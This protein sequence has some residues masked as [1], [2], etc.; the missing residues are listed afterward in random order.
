M[1]LL[2]VNIVNAQYCKTCYE[3][4]EV[5][6]W[7]TWKSYS[8]N[9]NFYSKNGNNIKTSYKFNIALYLCQHNKVSLLKVKAIEKTDDPEWDG[10]RPIVEK[11]VSFRN[12]NGLRNAEYLCLDHYVFVIFDDYRFSIPRDV[13]PNAFDEIKSIFEKASEVH[14]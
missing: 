13:Y 2:I 9:C 4:D 6:T 11:T 3:N 8:Y 5:L 10:R 7:K 14:L 12:N 1:M